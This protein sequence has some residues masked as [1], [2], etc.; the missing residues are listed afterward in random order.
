MSSSSAT[1]PSTRAAPAETKSGMPVRLRR[2][3]CDVLFGEHFQ[4]HNQ[5]PELDRKRLTGAGRQCVLERACEGR[6]QTGT[7][8]P[9]T[10]FAGQGFRG[11]VVAN[12]RGAESESQVSSG[13]AR[14][15]RSAC[16]LQLSPP[17][18]G[19]GRCARLLSSL[20]GLAMPCRLEG[21]VQ[22]WG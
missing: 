11:G 13:G 14:G 8:Q 5:V 9:P 3:H 10:I 21:N 20:P 4:I 7:S 15:M 19:K 18:S 22:G 1:T 12:V 2:F 6:A 16:D 17:G